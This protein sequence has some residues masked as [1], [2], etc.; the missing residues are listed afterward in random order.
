MFV[1]AGKS[2]FE[3]NMREKK[4][5]CNFQLDIIGLLRLYGEA[6]WEVCLLHLNNLTFIHVNNA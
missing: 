5:I 6:E 4:N 1:S 3:N 2:V